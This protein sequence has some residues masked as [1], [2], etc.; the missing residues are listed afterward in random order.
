MWERYQYKP[1][2]LRVNPLQT[3]HMVVTDNGSVFTSVMAFLRKR[4]SK[5]KGPGKLP[6]P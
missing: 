1:I 3:P 5:E 2:D 6:G 4:D